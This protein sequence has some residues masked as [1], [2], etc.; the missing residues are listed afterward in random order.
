LWAWIASI[1]AVAY[2]GGPWALLLLGI[3]ASPGLV[4][5]AAAGVLA[6]AFAVNAWGVHALR[7]LARVGV[8]AELAGTALVALLLLALAPEQ[9]P[10]ILG[11]TLGAQASSGGSTLAAMLAAVA[12]AGWVFLGFDAVVAASE[13]TRGADR[14]VPRAVWLS[15]LLVGA[16]VGLTAVAVTLGHPDPGA[17]VS[18][19]DADPIASAVVGA[20]GGWSTRPFAAVVL[21]AFVACAT[22]ALAAGSRNLLSIARDGVLPGARALARVDRR[23]VPVPALAAIALPAAAGLALGLE[24]SAIGTFIAFGTAVPYVAFLLIAV[25]A[26]HARTRGGWRAA[27][28]VRLGRAGLALNVAAVAWL[29]FET[30]NVAWPREALAGPGAPWY[31]VW[32]APLL[33]A[34]V[35]AAGGAW[36]ALSRGR[37]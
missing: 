18:G 7:R 33:V 27:G 25:A 22:A 13:E 23:G 16:L 5:A 15:A 19:R 6:V 32:A 14:H 1:T 17:V 31:Q 37:G 10:S 11:E 29:A 34:A 2:L 30:V 21:L 24:Q 28:P 8:G 36:L 20:L 3:D 12:V 9:D 4:V 35:L 26:L